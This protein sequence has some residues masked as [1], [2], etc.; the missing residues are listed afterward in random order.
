M[1]NVLLPLSLAKSFC[2]HVAEYLNEAGFV[3]DF[4]ASD[5]CVVFDQDLYDGREISE[6]S[7][8]SISNFCGVRNQGLCHLYPSSCM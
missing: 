8:T 3:P 5:Y 1:S 4:K 6:E 7:R 2:G